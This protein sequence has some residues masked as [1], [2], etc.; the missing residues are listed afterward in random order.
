VNAFVTLVTNDEYALGALTLIRSLK[1]C[2]STAPLVVLATRAVDG[3]EALATEGARIVE[4]DPLPVSD[5]FRARHARPA[6]HAAA[7]FTKG[8]KP[9]FHDPLDNFAKLRLWQLVELERVVFLDADTLVVR[10]IDRL[11]DYPELCAA[12]NLYE[13]LADMHR[14]NSGVFTARPCLRTFDRM[15]E[16]LDAEGAFWPRTDQTFLQHFWPE[17]HG[18]PYVFNTLQ[19]VYFALPQLWH[20]PSIRVVHYQYEKP[21]MQDHPKRDRLAP[22]I[23]LWWRI[24]DCH[25]LPDK[26]PAPA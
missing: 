4:V 26:L 1:L 23:D 13:S 18:L 15:L 25:G 8:S 6:L 3:L 11:F 19:Y 10:N 7:P 12:P 21:W 22:L 16:R 17:W 5:A 20:W 9:V 2:R 24:H 14:M